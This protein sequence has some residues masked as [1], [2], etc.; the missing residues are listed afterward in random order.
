MHNNEEARAKSQQPGVATTVLGGGEQDAGTGGHVTERS[1]ADDTDA[2][3]G[4]EGGGSD[5]RPFPAW[6]PRKLVRPQ[7]D[8]QI[9]AAF[10][11]LAI[12]VYGV[13]FFGIGTAFLP[14]HPAWCT[15][16]LWACALLGALIAN[17]LYLPRVIGMLAAGI[18]LQNIPWSAIDA[19]PPSW[20]TQMRAAA[21]ATIFLRCGLELDFGTMRKFKYPALRLALIPGLVEALYA[22]GL[23]VAVFNM[24]FTLSLCMGFILKAVG[25][26]LV[27]PAMFH[28]QRIGMGVAQ[29]IP[30]VVVIAASFDDIVAITG[31]AIFSTIAI[32]PYGSNSG[33]NAAWSIASGP[34]QVV[35]GILGGLIAG[36]AVGASKIWDTQLKR[37]IALYGSALLLMF[38]LEYWKLLSGGALGA[39]FTGLVGSNLWEKGIPKP[40]SAGPSFVYSPQCERWMSLIWRWVMEPILFV[41]VGSTLDFNTLSSG[42]IPKS[43][44]I[45]LTG[46]V[47]RMI[48]TYFSMSGFGYSRKEKLFYAIAWTP[49]ATVQAALSAAP[50]TLITNL[51]QG[52]PDYEQWV[53][54]G[55]DILTTGL[56]AIIISGTFGV[57]AIHFSAPFFLKKSETKGKQDGKGSKAEISMVERPSTEASLDSGKPSRD[58]GQIA[59]ARSLGQILPIRPQEMASI[60]QT[61]PRRPASAEGRYSTIDIAREEGSSRRGQR[62]VAGEDFELVA[63]YID[64]IRRLTSAVNAGEYSQEEVMELSDRV[65]HMQ[66]RLETEVGHREPSV[67]ELFRT[68]SVF[69]RVNRREENLPSG[70][71]RTTSTTQSCFEVKPESDIV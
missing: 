61:S 63:E 64:S 27:V 31:Y 11:I 28:L 66:R 50:L 6:L 8:T 2:D 55:N 26:G 34:V 21:L 71:R 65:L 29:G 54:W 59:S 44:L 10:V 37:L 36:A 18:L 24:P 17:Q 35:F 16:L 9:D 45:V 3:E 5:Q 48:V 23:G 22:A 56:F 39:L 4:G 30:S 43:V 32:T 47:L 57:L 1:A 70:S 13:L 7:V 15:L 58:R 20:G 67:R 52:D 14:G 53:T 49:K 38:F 68:A 41:T 19:F 40:V 42:T 69:H 60:K 33:V 62:L 51:K 25:P 46:G 12:V